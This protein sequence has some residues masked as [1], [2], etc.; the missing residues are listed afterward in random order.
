[1]KK[2]DTH[3]RQAKRFALVAALAVLV[4]ACAPA[5]LN[6]QAMSA[7]SRA[8]QPT[9]S[10][11]LGTAWGD[12]V[13]SQVTTVNLRR[14]TREPIAQ[15]QIG[16]ADKAYRGT[17]IN[18]VSLAAGT[19]SLSVESAGRPLPLYR[20]NGRYY[21]KGKTGQAYQLVYQNSSR[22]KTY[23][24]VASVD[25]LNVLTGRSASRYGRGYVL[26]PNGKLVIKGFRKSRSAVASFI[27]SRPSAGYANHSQAGDIRNTGVIGSVIYE[28]YNPNQPV[29]H[30]TAPQAFPADNGYAPPPQ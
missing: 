8:Q 1:M 24:I 23:E 11:R 22:Y 29:G 25:G 9:P 30:S 21:L 17:R 4:S 12:E 10:E 13:S 5:P 14:K 7:I 18:S 19:V 26:E 16:Y 20:D 2:H 3:K 28:L 27:F 6:Q 15:S